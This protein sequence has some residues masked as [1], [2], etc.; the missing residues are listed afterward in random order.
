M[1]FV[2]CIV[3][4]PLLAISPLFAKVVVTVTDLPELFVSVLPL[5][6]SIVPCEIVPLLVKLLSKSNLPLPLI[7]PAFS[8][9]PVI[10]KV[11]LFTVSP[12]FDSVD[13]TLAVLPEFMFNLAPLAI[14]KV[15]CSNPALSVV[16]PEVTEVVPAP[17]IAPLTVF[18]PAKP[19]LA[20]DTV[21]MPCPEISLLLM[22]ILPPDAT[23]AK[24][25]EP[26]M[27]FTLFKFTVLPLP[28][29]NPEYEPKLR[30]DCDPTLPTPFTFT[31]P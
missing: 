28:M 16:V 9:T 6:I 29:L 22:F 17:E 3:R 26:L 24:N 19:I 11:P 2:P 20:P 4:L 5:A 31:V 30:V 23:S 18:V 21:L 13:V 1:L 10:F 14:D 27:V 25:P 8:V 15:L 7:V 12:E